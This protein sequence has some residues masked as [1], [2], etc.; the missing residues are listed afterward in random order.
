M[1]TRVSFSPKVTFR[2]SRPFVIMSFQSFSERN[3]KRILRPKDFF[4]AKHLRTFDDFIPSIQQAHKEVQNR[5]LTFTNIQSSLRKGKQV[6]KLPSLHQQLIVRKLNDTLARVYKTRQTDRNKIC[7]TIQTLLSDP[8]PY[9]IVKC[10]IK[11]FFETIPRKSLQNLVLANHIFSRE[12]KWVFRRLFECPKISGSY[13]LPRG[14]ALS[15]TLSEKYLQTFDDRIKRQKGVFYYSRFVD[16][17]IV[18]TGVEPA[19][20]LNFIIDE[21]SKR[22]LKLNLRKTSLYSNSK[23]SFATPATAALPPPSFDF[24]GYAFSKAAH[25]TPACVSIALSKVKKI[26][27]RIARSFLAYSSDHD[28]SL[29]EARIRFLTS[30]YYIEGSS[31]Q[32]PLRAGVF[33]NY[34]IASDATGQMHELDCFLRAQI[35]SPRNIPF[36]RSSPLTSSLKKRLLTYTFEAGY[37]ERKLQRFSAGQIAKIKRCWANE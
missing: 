5:T 18:F 28:A 29:L 23:D 33:Y 25:N 35:L 24:L 30:N 8:T 13:G 12:T 7:R 6:L 31:S 36:R 17:I 11:S 37:S 10:D 1:G 20:V 2:A 4:Q 27:S 14:L 19:D 26:K 32:S 34:P 3:L 15:S 9:H 22:G 21:L 16:D